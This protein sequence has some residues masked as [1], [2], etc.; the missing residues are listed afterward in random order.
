MKVTIRALKMIMMMTMIIM[1]MLMMIKVLSTQSLPWSGGLE[2]DHDD[3]AD[4]D[5]HVKYDRNDDNHHTNQDAE[6]PV[7]ALE[8]GPQLVR[9]VTHR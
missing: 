3:D 2:S 6:H 9:L 7:L 1:I 8:W 4:Y 5:H